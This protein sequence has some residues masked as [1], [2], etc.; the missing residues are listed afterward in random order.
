MIA[1]SVVEVSFRG[2]RLPACDKYFIARPVRK[3]RESVETLED[4]K[5]GWLCATNLQTPDLQ[6]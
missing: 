2:N 4:S 6:L 5:Q 3:R 1:L